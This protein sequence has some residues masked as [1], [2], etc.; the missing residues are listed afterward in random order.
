MKLERYNNPVRRLLLFSL[1]LLF[2][3]TLSYMTYI[4]RTIWG[5]PFEICYHSWVEKPLLILLLCFEIITSY[6]VIIDQN[7]NSTGSK[8]IGITG[9]LIPIIGVL[10]YSIYHYSYNSQPY[11]TVFMRSESVTPYHIQLGF[12]FFF[13]VLIMNFMMLFLQPLKLWLRIVNFCITILGLLL[14]I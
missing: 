6:I 1:C 7:M 3:I 12:L 9:F 14:T 8:I 13:N 4:S 2:F 10:A 11:I 5:I